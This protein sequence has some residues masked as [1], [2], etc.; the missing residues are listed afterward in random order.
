MATGF[1]DVDCVTCPRLSQFLEDLREKHPDYH[2]LPVAPFGA[3][4]PHLLV[5]GLAPGMHG[6]NASSRPFTG[7]ASGVLLY[8]TLYKYGFASKPVSKSVDDGLALIDCCI[9]NTV[10]CLPPQ[11][12]PVAAEVNACSHFLRAEI[13]NLP[14][15]ALLIALGS[16]AHDSI[17]RALKLKKRDFKFAHNALHDLGD[18]L[19]L[20]DSYHCSRYN[21]QTKRLTPEMF[22]AVFAK[23]CLLLG[24]VK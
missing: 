9:T 24:K 3:D 12:R 20:I 8:E 2:N 13:N 18:G 10:K 4:K 22:E 23:A 17:I 21:T 14:E 7:D 19:R 15:G 6:A 11:N 5:V 16:V 1:F